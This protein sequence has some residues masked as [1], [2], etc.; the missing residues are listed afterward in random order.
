MVTV[1]KMFLV[2]LVVFAMSD[3][4][5]P[6]KLASRANNGFLGSTCKSFFNIRLDTNNPATILMKGRGER[7][8]GIYRVHWT[9]GQQVD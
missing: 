3:I 6:S 5:C 1:S 8:R 7:S 9:T 2:F 4:F